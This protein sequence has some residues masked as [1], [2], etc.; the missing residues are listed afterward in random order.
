MLPTLRHSP[1]AYAIEASQERPEDVKPFGLEKP[2]GAGAGRVCAYPAPPHRTGFP[3]PQVAVDVAGIG[4]A[5][6]AV[7]AMKRRPGGAPPTGGRQ[8][9]ECGQNAPPGCSSTRP[10]AACW[11]QTLPVANLPL[12]ITVVISTPFL[13]AARS[14]AINSISGIARPYKMSNQ[15]FEE[16]AMLV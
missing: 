7:A 14:A 12:C 13:L 15:S 16:V 3:G 5:E 11:G 9:R 1:H 8:G 2:A 4:R 10:E 6:A